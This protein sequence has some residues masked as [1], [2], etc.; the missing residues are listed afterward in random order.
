VALIVGSIGASNAPKAPS[1]ASGSSQTSVKLVSYLIPDT[2]V[3]GPGSNAD[4]ELNEHIACM[5]AQGFDI[6]D[7]E[8]TANGWTISVDP[9]VVDVGSDAWREAAF[10]TCRLPLPGSGNFILGL[11]KERVDRF[12]AC[13]NGQGFDLPEPTMNGDGEYVFDLT[14]TDI[15]MNAP[16]W[17]R[18]AFVTCSPDVGP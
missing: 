15:D 13:V 4:E 8:R 11:S 3:G 12:V 9:S 1:V 2:S 14:G 10:V 6:Q 17:N 16:E 5:R 18:A 7:P